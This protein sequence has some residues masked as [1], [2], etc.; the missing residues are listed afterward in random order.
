VKNVKLETLWLNENK[1]VAVGPDAFKHLTNLNF[2]ELYGNP[3][4]HPDLTWETNPQKLGVFFT[5]ASG[6]RKWNNENN[7]CVTSYDVQPCI[8]DCSIQNL[9]H[10][11]ETCKLEKQRISDLLKHKDESQSGK[12]TIILSTSIISILILITIIIGQSVIIS[13][14]KSKNAGQKDQIIRLD[15]LAPKHVYEQ[16]DLP[17]PEYTVKNK[18]PSV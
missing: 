13:K 4:M 9:E 18:K 5:E 17:D 1:I 3:C 8:K 10:E 6:Y 11:V 16:V 12:N 7:A 2:L 14:L 15:R